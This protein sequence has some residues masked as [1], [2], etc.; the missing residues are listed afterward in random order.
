MTKKQILLNLLKVVAVL[1]VLILVG[2]L[3]FTVGEV[4]V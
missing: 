3:I 1:V 4:Q 2:Y